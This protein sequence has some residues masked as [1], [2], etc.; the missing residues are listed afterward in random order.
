MRL[1]EATPGKDE[2]LRALEPKFERPD[3]ALEWFETE[4]LP[5]FSFAKARDLVQSSRGQEVL[6]YVAATEAG[7]HAWRPSR[8]AYC[9][10]KQ[11]AGFGLAR[12][13]SCRRSPFLQACEKLRVVGQSRSAI[14]D[15]ARLDELLAAR[16][17]EQCKQGLCRIVR[18]EPE[19]TSLPLVEELPD[20]ADRDR[21][22]HRRRNCRRCRL[23]RRNN[24]RDHQGKSGG[25]FHRQI[26]SVKWAVRTSP[27]RP[28]TERNARAALRQVMAAP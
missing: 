19:G 16:I 11:T 5:G 17:M 21:S 27:D 15:Q 9:G 12:R 2:I 13:D 7:L 18:R 23:A 22:L 3:L 24:E 25:Q 26:S 8:P 6:N 14:M 20:L 28:R 10:R 1:S 4:P